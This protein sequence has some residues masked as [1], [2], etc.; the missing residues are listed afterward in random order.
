MSVIGRVWNGWLKEYWHRRALGLPRPISSR[1]ADIMASWA[2]DLRDFFPEAVRM[3]AL[4][5]NHFSFEHSRLLIDLEEKE[6]IRKFP[7]AVADLL[8]LYLKCPRSY[9]FGD[10]HTK[11]LWLD[12]KNSGLKQEKL[13]AVQEAMYR[14]LNID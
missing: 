13:Q 11:K 7:E 8:L 2:I 6:M 10:Q 4:F 14:K 3:L 5:E 12:L 9:L 1:E